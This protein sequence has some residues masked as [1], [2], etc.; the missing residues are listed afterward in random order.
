M[1]IEIQNLVKRY[2]DFVAVDDLSFE[3]EQGEIFGLLGPNGAGKTTT[4][5]VIMDI[6]S[7]DA[8]SVTV[9]GQPPGQAKGQESGLRLLE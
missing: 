3:V 5:R 2:G 8:G 9:L 4:I 7:P 1:I 6:L